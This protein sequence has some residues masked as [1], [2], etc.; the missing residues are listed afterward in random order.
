VAISIEKDRSSKAISPSDSQSFVCS[1]VN[2]SPTM[3]RN[4]VVDRVSQTLPRS[5]S[6]E[7]AESGPRSSA[8]LHQRAYR[9]ARFE[10]R[11]IGQDDDHAP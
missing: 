3:T 2:S 11:R 1:G 7:G 9:V 4:E 10:W 8:S 6:E 5:T